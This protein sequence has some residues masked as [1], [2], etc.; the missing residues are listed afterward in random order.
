MFFSLNKKRFI[1]ANFGS[2]GC[3]FSPVDEFLF[4]LCRQIAEKYLKRIANIS[5]VAFASILMLAL[6]AIPHHHHQDG[7]PCFQTD[8]ATHDCDHQH[9][10]NHNPASDTGSENPNCV[11]HANF[12]AQQADSG[13][14]LKSFSPAQADD[15]PFYTSLFFSVLA[16]FTIS[17][18]DE[19][20]DYGEL[21]LF[22]PDTE[23]P[24]PIGL[25]APPF[26][27]S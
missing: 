22:V 3:F 16:D 27:I 6:S 1:S 17:L 9:S 8:Q 20:T 12:I 14:R 15:H 11:A 25:R 7:M 10:R 23:R 19:K 18:P 21:I 13:S 2:A 24:D 5:V 4:Y 26:P